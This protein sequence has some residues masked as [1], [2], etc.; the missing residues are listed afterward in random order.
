MKKVVAAMIMMTAGVAHAQSSVTLTGVIGGGFRWQDGVKGG[1]QFGFDNNSVTGN[2]FGIRGKE[3]LGGGVQAI[4]DLESGFYSGTGSQ[5]LTNTLFSQA[6]YVGL[7]G[8]FGRLTFGRQFSAFEDLALVLDPSLGRGSAPTVPAAFY[9]TNPFNYDSRFSNTVKYRVKFGGLAFS[10]SYSLGGVAG[11]IRAGS[12]WSFSTLYQY[13][14]LSA[15]IS[16][17]HS[18]NSNASQWAQAVEAGG[19]WQLGAARL[20]LNYTTLAV[21]GASAFAPQRRD[22]IPAGGIVYQVTPALQLTAAFYDDIAANL[23]NVSDAGGHKITSY[24]IAEYFLSKRTELYAEVDRN[25]FSG[26]YKLDPVNIAAFNLRPGASASTG[27]SIGV[28]TQF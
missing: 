25:G 2:S 14:T 26:A 21:T 7:V 8:G 19:T 12:S 9:A 5:Y 18:Y 6:A 4:F 28:L 16:Y 22:K 27:V 1:S 3:D 24:L 20:Y 15:G 17:Q 11:D 23:G 10:S 13:Q